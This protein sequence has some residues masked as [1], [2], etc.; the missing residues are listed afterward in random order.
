M[1][2]EI[3]LSLS[4]HPSPLLRAD[5][6]DTP[7]L[8][9]I[10]PPERALLA[11]AAHISDLNIK[12]AARAALVSAEHPSTICRAV[13]AAIDSVHLAAF[14]RKVLEVEETVLRGDAGLVGAYNIVPLTAVIGEFSGWTRRLEWL[15]G[16]LQFVASADKQSRGGCSGA[17]LI[18][19]LRSELQS[20]YVDI[21]QTANTLVAAAETAWLKQVSAWILYGRLPTGRD[22]FIQQEEGGEFAIDESMLPAFVSEAAAS[23]M[24]FIGKSLNHVRVKSSVDSG[25]QG[26]DHL[27]SQLREL[28]SLTY[29]LDPATFSRAIT[30]IRLSLSRNTLQK[31]LPLSKVLEM[32]HLLREFFLLGRGE[33]AMALTQQADEKLQSRWKR[34]DNLA[35]EKRD[36]LGSFALKEG[37]VTT[38]LS[39][40]W[41]ALGLMQGQHADEDEGLELAR[42]L[43]RL[44]LAKPTQGTPKKG[45]GTTTSGSRTLATTPFRNLLLSV[46]VTMTMQIPSPLDMFLTPADLHIYSTINAYLLSVRRAHI[47]LTDL[48]KVTSL[49]RQHPAPPGPPAGSTRGGRARVQ[50][51]RE[52]YATRSSVMRSAWVT[53]SAAIFFLAETEAYLQTEVVAGLWDGFDEWLTADKLVDPMAAHTDAPSEDQD[54]DDDDDIWLA[55]T[56]SKVDLSAAEPPPNTDTYE[57]D[58][59]TLSVAHVRYLHALSHRL[60]LTD[61]GYTEALLALLI[62][63]DHLVAHVHRLHG[64]WSS[65]DLEA[66]A[67][68]M[69]AYVDLGDEEASVR[70]A[71][72]EVEGKVKTGVEEVI[73]AL[74]AIEADT[75]FAE[76]V[77]AGDG[78]GAAMPEAGEYVPRRVGGVERLL[79][80]LDFGGWFGRKSGEEEPW[81]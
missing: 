17:K 74:R 50:L 18:D 9:A 8:A 25:L 40:T 35:Y 49:R 64:I 33:F 71:L 65:M 34:A 29:P 76:G 28:S 45:T 23:S 69:D 72:R 5:A 73:G 68:V 55:E 4:G 80:K 39:K 16:V 30:A 70:A 42:G 1:L 78:E 75:G 7:A 62:D 77:P 58:P 81:R 26:L 15:W 44:N 10:T 27:S 56:T 60:L 14:Q 24:L 61:T 12:L 19:R 46:P 37:E 31:L 3:L 21:E 2:H 79:M 6:A 11:T 43:L 57:H 20:G 63:I 47:H 48:W 53:A 13:A 52:R 59:Q 32:L 22:F 67:G 41:A 38:V 66:D 51:L 54:D 36:G